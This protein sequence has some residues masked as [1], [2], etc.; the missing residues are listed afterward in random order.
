MISN[1]PI[2][3]TIIVCAAG[4]SS[5]IVLFGAM[6]KFDTVESLWGYGLLWIVTFI[7]IYG[8]SILIIYNIYQAW[9]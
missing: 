4:I 6:K 3:I 1:A 2:I 7:F 9:W 5:L 8:A